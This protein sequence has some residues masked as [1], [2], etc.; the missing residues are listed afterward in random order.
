M[1]S[2]VKNGREKKRE[3]NQR[4][5]EG[6]IVKWVGAKMGE[7]RVKCFN[8]CDGSLVLIKLTVTSRLGVI[9]AHYLLGFRQLLKGSQKPL[10]G[11]GQRRGW[12]NSL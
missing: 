10:L 8:N 12:R 3:R 5:V 4:E 11:Q 1:N 7:S 2:S 9:C 6:Q